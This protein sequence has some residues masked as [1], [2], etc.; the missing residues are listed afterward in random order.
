M[1]TILYLVLVPYADKGPRCSTYFLNYIKNIVANVLATSDLCI[2]KR[3]AAVENRVGLNDYSD[4]DDEE[5]ELTN[6]DIY[7]TR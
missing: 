5:H 7:F 4:L 1:H 6:P 3:L 2:L